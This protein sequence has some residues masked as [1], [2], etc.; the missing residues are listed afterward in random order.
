MFKTRVA[1][2]V[3]PP[4]VSL[5]CSSP[6]WRAHMV[7][8]Y[9]N[10][11]LR[12]KKFRCSKVGLLRAKPMRGS[13]GVVIC[14]SLLAF[15]WGGQRHPGVPCASQQVSRN[16]WDRWRW[17]SSS[18]WRRR[19]HPLKGSQRSLPIY[20]SRPLQIDYKN[21]SDGDTLGL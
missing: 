7:R 16:R 9:P 20:W 19:S 17:N 13:G 5:P 21:W 11:W 18:L 2:R 3:R 1:P 14:A 8:F 15:L 4:D 10:I 6:R 12:V